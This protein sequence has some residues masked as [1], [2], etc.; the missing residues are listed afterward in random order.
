MLVAV[1]QTVGT[2]L[3]RMGARLA[4]TAPTQDPIPA[5]GGSESRR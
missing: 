1:R 4:A 5:V 2:A 3:V